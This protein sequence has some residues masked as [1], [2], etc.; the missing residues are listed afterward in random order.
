MCSC[1]VPTWIP[2]RGPGVKPNDAFGGGRNDPHGELRHRRA[3]GRPDLSTVLSARALQGRSRPHPSPQPGGGPAIG[4]GGGIG[5]AT[6][7]PVA[8]A[9]PATAATASSPLIELGAL[10]R[11]QVWLTLGV[12]AVGSGVVFAVYT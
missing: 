6:V 2:G 8:L 12:A 9:V 4:T 3:E 1:F 10:R 7:A 5:L 11:P